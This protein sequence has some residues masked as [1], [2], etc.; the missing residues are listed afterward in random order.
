MGP[1][2][3]GIIEYPSFCSSENEASSDFNFGNLTPPRMFSTEEP[4]FT[5]D[6]VCCLLVLLFTSAGGYDMACAH[7][8][9]RDQSHSV[10]R[11]VV[12]P[13][14]VRCFLLLYGLGFITF[15]EQ[16]RL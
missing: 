3:P 14:A 16:L 2:N 4:V 8:P 15:L 1:I 5:P 13:S 11:A 6:L 9:P 10:F 12:C 7:T